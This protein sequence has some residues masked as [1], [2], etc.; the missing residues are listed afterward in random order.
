MSARID[1]V[2]IDA[3]EFLAGIQAQI[4]A[5]KHVVPGQAEAV[6]FFRPLYRA[7]FQRYALETPTEENFCEQDYLLSNPD[8]ADAVKRGKF[9]SG[10]EH[11]VKYGRHE[12]RSFQ[13]AEFVEREYLELN[14][15]VAKS[16]EE[17]QFASGLDHWRQRGRLEGRS[18]RK[19]TP[20]L[21]SHLKRLRSEMRIRFAQIGEVPPSPSTLRAIVGRQIIHIIRRVLWWHTQSVAALGDVA[22]RAFK[23][24]IAVL[25]HLGAAQ[26]EN[27]SALVSIRDELNG[28]AT[29]AEQGARLQ[30]E[31][32]ARICQLESHVRSAAE[33]NVTLGAHVQE[34]SL[35]LNALEEK[36]NGFAICFNA[37]Q[38]KAERMTA[39]IAVQRGR[40]TTLLGASGPDCGEPARFA[41]RQAGEDHKLDALYLAFEDVFRGP[42]EEIKRR[43]TVYLEF[44]EEA[45]A[46]ALQAPILDLGCG[47]GEWLELLRDNGTTAKGVDSN[48]AMTAQCRTRGLDVEEGEALAYL[49]SL[50]DCSLGLI[51]CFHMIEH[52]PFVSVV[53]LLD[54]AVRVLRPG[55]LLI[56]ETPNPKNLT[57][58]SQSFYLD[59][60]HL[61]PLPPEMLRF[62]VEAAG[63]SNCQELE[64]QPGPFPPDYESLKISSHLNRLLYGPRDYGLIGRRP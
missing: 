12:G 26:E 9:K 4:D 11:W 38:V 7:G 63:F 64:L 28:I 59:P 16:I 43:L 46:G 6:Q 54:E 19:A 47:R 37:Q 27:D 57:V 36:V 13:P 20:R 62:F 50:P 22:M 21:L 10:F 34:L 48:L 18:I 58:A 23:E 32:E 42:R 17:G 55:G 30:G 2:P 31:F 24:Q 52:I 5:G 61:K 51:T 56:L 33:L 60:T 35:R 40:V 44:V 41:Q 45:R 3:E 39:E 8:I 49:R 53:S 14:P 29:Q 1:I 25:E 15:D